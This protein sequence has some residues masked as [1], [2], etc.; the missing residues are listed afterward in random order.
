[1]DN[2]KDIDKETYDKVVRLLREHF[3][4]DKPVLDYYATYE[5]PNGKWQTTGAYENKEEAI[6]DMKFHAQGRRYIIAESEEKLEEEKKQDDLTNVSCK[7]SGSSHF[8]ENSKCVCCGK[9]KD[10]G[11]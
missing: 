11:T 9:V 1:M 10:N 4:I 5:L 6:E 2:D 3:G 7:G 8:Y